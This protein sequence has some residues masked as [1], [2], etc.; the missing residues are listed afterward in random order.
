MRCYILRIVC[1]ILVV[2]MYDTTE[3]VWTDVYKEVADLLAPLPNKLSQMGPKSHPLEISH[4]GVTPGK[5]VFKPS[6]P[7]YVPNNVPVRAEG[8]RRMPSRLEEPALLSAGKTAGPIHTRPVPSGRKKSWL[9][10]VR[11]VQLHGAAIYR[12]KRWCRQHIPDHIYQ[13]VQ[14]Q[15]FWQDRHRLRHRYRLRSCTPFQDRI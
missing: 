12:G 8:F 5:P 10:A 7:G 2:F 13:Y 15:F 9:R 11:R 6:S 3:N 14:Q 1:T 4:V